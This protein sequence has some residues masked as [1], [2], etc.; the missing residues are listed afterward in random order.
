MDGKIIT[1]AALNGDVRTIPTIDKGLAIEGACADAKATGDRFG[2]QAAIIEEHGKKIADNSAAIQTLR[3]ENG[4][5]DTT[6][7]EHKSLIDANATKIAAAENNIGELHRKASEA[8]DA[9]DDLKEKATTGEE[10][11]AEVF[12][13]LDEQATDINDNWNMI[14]QEVKPE[15]AEAKNDIVNLQNDVDGLR[16]SFDKTSG[17]IQHFY[18]DPLIERNEST[19]AVS[20][21]VCTAWLNFVTLDEIPYATVL[22][23]GLPAPKNAGVFSVCNTNTGQ[24]HFLRLEANNQDGRILTAIAT[25]P[26]HGHYVGNVAYV[27]ADAV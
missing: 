10:S 5:Q 12:E 19:Y 27:V 22:F 6:L 18:Y 14:T 26:G 11:I 2:A 13:R 8:E 3:A 21:G 16:H 4:V 9:I 25:L 17:D 7:G 24:M 1:P 20:C 23:E 15:L